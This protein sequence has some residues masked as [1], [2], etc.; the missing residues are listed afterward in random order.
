MEPISKEKI[1]K[2]KKGQKYKPYSEEY[3]IEISKR[4]TG[5]NN[6]MYGKS[7]YSVWVEKDGVEEAD[8]KM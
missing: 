8:R 6:P 3:K 2:F 1:S 7:V 4:V 5:Q